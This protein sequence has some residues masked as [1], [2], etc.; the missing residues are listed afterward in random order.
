[1]LGPGP[2]H[3]L[4][5]SCSKLLIMIDCNTVIYRSNFYPYGVPFNKKITLRKPANQLL[6]L[7]EKEKSLIVLLEFLIKWVLWVLIN[8]LIRCHYLPLTVVNYLKPRLDYYIDMCSVLFVQHTSNWLY[9][10]YLGK[11]SMLLNRV[12]SQPHCL[13]CDFFIWILSGLFSHFLKLWSRKSIAGI[14]GAPPLFRRP[15]GAEHSLCN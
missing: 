11:A 6:Q 4:S 14:P 7:I 1:M 2:S 13:E 3:H 10:F 12:V 8:V 15:H 5:S 9:F